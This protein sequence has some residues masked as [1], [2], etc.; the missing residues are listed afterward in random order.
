[1]QHVGINSNMHNFEYAWLQWAMSFQ[2]QV[3]A[4]PVLHFALGLVWS[5]LPSLPFHPSLPLPPCHRQLA[6]HRRAVAA[7]PF[8]LPDAVAAVPF[9]LPDAG[10]VRLLRRHSVALAKVFETSAKADADFGG[11]DEL[12]YDEFLEAIAAICVF[13]NPDPYQSVR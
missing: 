5:P 10:A 11:S 3:L 8:G 4:F 12:V 13:K 2:T 6:Q 7:V 9:G 1:M